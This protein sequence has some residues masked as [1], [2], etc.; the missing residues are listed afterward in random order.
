[1]TKALVLIDYQKEWLD[2]KSHD[3]LGDLNSVIRNTN[4]LIDACRKR[5]Y[6]LIF[7]RHVEQD[8]TEQ[9][10]ENSEGAELM[11][12]IHKEP[13]DVLITKHK[14]NPFYETRMETELA[15]IKDVVVAGILTNNCVRSF[16][17][18]AYDR[19]FNLTVVKDCCA[20]FDDQTQEFTFSDL[21][22]T[23]EE[24]V[25]INLKDFLDS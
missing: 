16:I 11:S 2:P 6:K 8:S 14:I 21:G 17:A 20:T 3:Y 1:M 7:T 5:D 12:E 15:G 4:Q 25:F 13:N 24:I 23:R 9:W 19:G 10:S 18:D 22:S